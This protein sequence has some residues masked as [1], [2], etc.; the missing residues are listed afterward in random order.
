MPTAAGEFSG[1]GI[2]CTAIMV[3]LIRKGGAKFAVDAVE[4][5]LAW[6]TE[7]PV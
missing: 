3:A 5:P 6:A 2:T 1:E 4:V 7:T